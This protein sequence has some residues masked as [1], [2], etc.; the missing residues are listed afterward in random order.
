MVVIVIPI[1]WGL[2]KNMQ[3]NVIHF[4]N[5][6]SK[7][8]PAYLIEKDG[9]G[10]LSIAQINSLYICAYFRDKENQVIQRELV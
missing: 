10:I 7:I 6:T 5:S 4:E 2:G 8:N 3:S 9:T 1:F